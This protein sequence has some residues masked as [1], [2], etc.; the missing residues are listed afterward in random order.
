MRAPGDIHVVGARDVASTNLLVFFPLTFAL[1]WTAWFVSAALAGP[2]DTGFFGVR[3]PIFLVGVFAPAL[4]AIA[5][6]MTEGH[7]GVWRLL[8]RIGR[9]QVRTR[10][11]VF[12]VG[13]LAAVKLAAALVHRVAIGAWPLFGDTPVPLMLGAILLSTWAQAGEEIGWRGFALPRLAKQLGLGGASILLGVIW[14]L[15]HLPL[16]FLPGTGSDGQSFPLYLLHVTAL[17]VAMAW[18]YWKTGRSLLL[19]MLMHASVNNTTDI[20]H[21]AVLGATNPFSFSGSLVAWVTVG[22]SWMAAAPLLFQMRGADITT[23]TSS[24]PRHSHLGEVA[25]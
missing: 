19:V 9:W 21:T 20:V 18:L 5:L 1:T 6:T 7:A 11:Y 3:G 4:V 22:L 17:S 2:N 15:W 23:G 14:A 13:Y 16:F 8:A 10:W 12:A 25:V 24:D